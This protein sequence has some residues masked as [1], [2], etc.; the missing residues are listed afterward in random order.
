MVDPEVLVTTRRSLHAVGEHVL[1]AALFAG[2]RRIGLERDFQPLRGHRHALRREAAALQFG[3]DRL[4]PPRRRRAAR[5]QP[6][7]DVVIEVV[8]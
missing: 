6:A 1:G 4:Q 8:H 5:L 2:R 7:R 3:F